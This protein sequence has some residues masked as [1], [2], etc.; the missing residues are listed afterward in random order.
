[1]VKVPLAASV[2]RWISI[3]AVSPPA[4]ISLWR[5]FSRASLP[6]EI[7]SLM[8]TCRQEKGQQISQKKKKIEFTN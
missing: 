7:S 2:C 1:M 4:V 8:N 5:S 6:L 3:G